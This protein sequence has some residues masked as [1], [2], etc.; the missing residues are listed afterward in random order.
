[1][2]V[3]LIVLALTAL[4]G[5]AARRPAT[6]RLM[7]ENVQ[8]TQQSDGSITCACNDPQSKIDARDPG[9]AHFRCADGK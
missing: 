5:C 1:M 3:A 6:H 8:C 9:R 7:L 2:R 4:L